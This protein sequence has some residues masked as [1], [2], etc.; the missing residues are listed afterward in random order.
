MC[1]GSNPKPIPP[2]TPLPPPAPVP[3]PM[4]TDV[5]PLTTS[6]QRANRVKALKFGAL[7]TI[8][9]SPQG[10]V[11]AGPDLIT[12]SAKKTVGS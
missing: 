5:A 8:K 2:P 7:S 12:P 4:P 3:T 1:G 6:E 9:T 10:I 11:G